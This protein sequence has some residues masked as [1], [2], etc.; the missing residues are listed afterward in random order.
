MT[1]R[2]LFAAAVLL[3]I[4]S[5]SQSGFADLGK[6][7]TEQVVKLKKGGLSTSDIRELCSEESDDDEDSPSA[8]ARRRSVPQ[9]N[10][11]QRSSTARQCTTTWGMCPMQVP[12][13]SGSA[14][15]CF[16]NYGQF[17]GIAR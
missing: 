4:M 10:S 3:A 17:P 12:I 5:A 13:P 14:C 9:Q 2:V 11:S 15:T 8:R 6:C 16:N 1:L 7:S